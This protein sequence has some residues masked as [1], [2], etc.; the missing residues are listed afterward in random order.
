MISPISPFPPDR[1]IPAVPPQTDD[2]MRE[3]ARKLEAAFL[4]SM[5][6]AAGVGAAR[7]NLGGGLGEEQFTSFLVQATADQMVARGGIGLA[8]SL[9]NSMKT[10]A[11]G[12]G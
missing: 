10:R 4:S 6:Q 8:E 2:A 3:S 5:L 1:P 12:R 11:D 9:F 7:E